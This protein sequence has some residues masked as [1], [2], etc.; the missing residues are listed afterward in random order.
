MKWTRGFR[1]WK[2][3]I[4]KTVTYSCS[5]SWVWTRKYLNGFLILHIFIVSTFLLLHN[6]Q[7]NFGSFFEQKKSKSVTCQQEACIK[8][9]LGLGSNP[10]PMASGC[11]QDVGKVFLN[12]DLL[13]VNISHNLKKHPV[14][15]FRVVF[16][17]QKIKSIWI[18]FYF[19]L[20][21]VKHA[22]KTFPVPKLHEAKNENMTFKLLDG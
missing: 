19:S 22:A 5:C 4:W 11:T 14:C 15:N 10:L 9:S 6:T 3:S 21:D 20:C 2:L 16:E 13:L 7:H 12:M 18:Y 17:R 1:Q 8:Q